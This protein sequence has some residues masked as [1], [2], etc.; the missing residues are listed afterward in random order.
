M[1]NFVQLLR[2]QF[3][4]ISCNTLLRGKME[5]KNILILLSNDWKSE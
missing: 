3:G 1:L 5:F 4:F 2:M